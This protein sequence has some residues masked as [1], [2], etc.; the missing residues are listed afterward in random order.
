M[1]F[2]RR[3]GGSIQRSVYHGNAVFLGFPLFETGYGGNDFE[4]YNVS[5]VFGFEKPEV[6]IVSRCRSSVDTGVYL[7]EAHD[8]TAVYRVSG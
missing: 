3:N 8:R 4:V 5:D 6:G 2:R 7:R 1:F